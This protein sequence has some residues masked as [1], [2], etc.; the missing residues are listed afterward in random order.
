VRPRLPALAVGLLALAGLTWDLGGY[1][2]LEPDEGR[3]AEVMREIAAEGPWWLPRLN[4]LPYV[5]KPIVHFAAGAAALRVF[6]TS[7]TAA[8]LPSL[9]FTLGTILVVGAF[10]RRTIGPEA[11]WQAGLITAATPFTLAYART[12]IF[13]ATLTFCLTAALAAFF[14]AVDAAERDR[15][16]DRWSLT[17]WVAVGLGVLTKGPVAL[18]VPLLVAVPY[19]VWRRRVWAVLD[20]AG[21]L[22][23]LA[24]ILPWIFA[25]SSVVP[26]FL[27]YVLFVE[28]AQRLGT[29]VL[30]R[31]EPWWYF[32]PILVAAA[33]PWSV[34]L[35]RALPHALGAWR[36]RR[37]DPRVVYGVLWI[38]LPLLLFSLSKSKRPQYMLPLV[39][40]VGLLSALWWSRFR[41]RLPGTRLAGGV[42]VALGVALLVLAPV[43]PGWID[44]RATVGDAIGPTAVRLGIVL[45]VAGA[46]AIA[47]ATRGTWALPALALPVAALPFVSMSLMDRIGED[48]S[49]RAAAA[50]VQPFLTA[51]TEIVAVATYPLSLP[52]YLGRTF[53]LSTADGGELTS[54]YIRLRHEHLRTIAGSRLRPPDWWQEALALC[55]RPRLFVVPADRGDLRE[56]LA[57]ALALLAETRK[58]AIYGPCGGDLLA[59]SS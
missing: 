29:D 42:L 17:A 28:T 52:F 33:L 18:A 27:R 4:G 41:D 14:L 49:S 24:V 55:D 57:T 7:E 10:A 19:A 3:N 35:A 45:V 32:F 9:V 39:P 20:P 54:N 30:G 6:G 56:R 26:D 16:P 43:I 44:T 53:T 46:A 34:V 31:T 22:L 8:R 38:L 11:G 48:R 12:V 13:D 59:R 36:A 40:P 25:V 51:E 21:L 5:D 47:F 58:F 23:L 15:P 50:A 37:I 2:L 1:A